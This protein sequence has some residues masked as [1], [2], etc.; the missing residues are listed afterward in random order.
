RPPKLT[1][2]AWQLYL[3][4]WIQQQQASSSRKLNFAQAAKEASQEY[5]SLSEEEKEACIGLFCRF[6]VISSYL[7]PYKRR[8]QVAKDVR[9]NPASRRRTIHFILLLSEKMEYEA[10]RRLYEDGS[11]GYSSSINFSILSGS[12]AFPAIKIESESKSKGFATDDGHGP[13]HICS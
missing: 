2:S 7:R 5:A 3:T 4:D 1:P 8:S 12:P 13:Y 10:A 11:V 9:M 6:D